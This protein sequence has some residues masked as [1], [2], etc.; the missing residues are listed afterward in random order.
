MDLQIKQIIDIDEN[1]LNTITTWVYD[2]HRKRGSSTFDGV[3]GFMKHCMQKDRFPQTYGLFLDNNIIGMFQITDKDLSG[4]PWLLNVYIDEKY[5]N[6]GY[7]RKLIESVASMAIKNTNFKEL[8]LYT[9]NIG[10]Y[11][12]FGWQFVPKKNI[13]SDEPGIQRL[14]KLDLK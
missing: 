13:Y 6:M 3:K 11:E 5:R 2:W 8:F 4:R 10:L 14:Y 1:T 12:K 7:G 9:G